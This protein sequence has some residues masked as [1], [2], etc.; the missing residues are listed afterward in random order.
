MR[1]QARESVQGLSAY[2]PVEREG[3]NLSDNANLFPVNPAIQQALD[4]LT[5]EQLRGYPSGYG[6]ALC[7][8][9]AHRHDVTPEHVLTGNGSSDLIDLLIRT[10]TDPGSQVAYHPPSFSMIPLWTQCNGAVPE[11]IPLQ[12]AFELDVPAYQASQARVGFIC[13]PNNP[14]GNVFPLDQV[15]AIAERFPGLLV[16][17]EAYVRFTDEPSATSLLEM[18]NV[19]ILRS[20]SKDAGLA[21]LRFGYALMPPSLAEEVR[22]VRG[23]FRVPRV[24]E[25]VALAALHHDDHVRSIVKTVQAERQRVAE[26]VADLGL[27]PFPSETNFVLIETPWPGDQIAEALAQRGVLVRAFNE[28]SLETCMRV[29]IGPPETNGTFLAALTDLL[30][31][32]GP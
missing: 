12:G 22:K 32:G 20:L 25:H 4:T 10:F 8:A 21:G 11:P 24:T 15:E 2:Q 17:D 3:L 7:D 29:T 5:P 16:L 1:P 28:A 14:T 26:A 31:E 6:E 23:P 13:R 19:A 30:E 27:S 18:G 9:L